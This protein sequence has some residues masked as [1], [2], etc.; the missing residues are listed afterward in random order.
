MTVCTG[1]RQDE[2]FRKKINRH[3]FQEKD[4]EDSKTNRNRRLW[5]C[6]QSS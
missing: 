6:P 2:C 3:A 1:R 5:L 4:N